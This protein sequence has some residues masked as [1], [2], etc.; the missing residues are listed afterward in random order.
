MI[1]FIEYTDYS[2]L[3]C[4]IHQKLG[5]NSSFENVLQSGKIPNVQKIKLQNIYEIEQYLSGGD[6]LFEEQNQNASNFLVDLQTIDINKYVN[7]S[8]VNKFFLIKVKSNHLS[9]LSFTSSIKQ[10][11]P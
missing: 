10:K 1:T 2:L 4:F 11:V 9:L 8:H 3:L 5:D 7:F 6:G